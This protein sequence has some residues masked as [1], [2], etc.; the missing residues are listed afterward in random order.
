MTTTMIDPAHATSFLAEGRIAVVGASDD[1][2]NFGRSI[3]GE[4]RDRG[5]DAVPVN[6]HAT[7]VAD[8]D[9]YPSLAQVPGGVDCAVVMVGTDA[10]VGVVQQCID[11]SIG[12]VWLFKGLGGQGAVSDTAV[13]MCEDHG[14]DVIPGACPLMFLEPVAWFHRVHRSIRR[15]RGAVARPSPDG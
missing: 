14:I 3:L 1:P 12:R 4:L 9:C 8:G 6:P 11:L 2:A 5:L 10:A 13:Q 15:A 7:T